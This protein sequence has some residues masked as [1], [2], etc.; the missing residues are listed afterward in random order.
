MSFKKYMFLIITFCSL[1]PA[2]NAQLDF[3]IPAESFKDYWYAGKAEIA[4]Y[5]MEQARY[6]ELHPGR[7]VLIFVT[8]DFSRSKQVKLDHPVRDRDD[9]VKVMKLNLTKKFLT[10]IYPYSVMMSMFTPINT[11]TYDNAL[12][13][14]TSTQ[15]WCGHVF[16]QMNHRKDDFLVRSFSYF[17]SEGD[18]TYQVKDY[19]A[20]DNIWN[21]IR[22]DPNKLPL[23][24][25][26]MIPSTL[27]SR[28]KHIALLPET[29]YASLKTSNED[30]RH[31]IYRIEYEKSGRVL[32]ITF[33]KEFPF[34]ILGW[35][36]KST[37]IIHGG[38]KVLT[39]S[40]RLKEYVHTDYWNKNN[41]QDTV[42]REKL[43][44]PQY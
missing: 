40:A 33:E 11:E 10:G 37:G 13:I 41:L 39:S 18:Q 28:L 21:L 12:K 19:F 14:T 22:L 43:G 32:S 1:I 15:E 34:R 27:E 30:A 23:G 5:E 38:N 17:E 44:L 4:H 7:A 29:V 42:W 31:A 26:I 24:E 25:A 16:T 6:G 9:A 3:E 8:E 2:T 36:E 35:E 20:E